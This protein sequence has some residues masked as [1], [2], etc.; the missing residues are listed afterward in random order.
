MFFDFVPLMKFSHIQKGLHPE[1]EFTPNEIC[2]LYEKY[3]SLLTEELN[4][5]TGIAIAHGWRST[6]YEQ[7]PEMSQ[8]N[9]T[10]EEVSH[11]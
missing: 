2:E 8:G 3:I 1:K 4:E 6:R 7:G 11:R 10:K 5:L 9:R